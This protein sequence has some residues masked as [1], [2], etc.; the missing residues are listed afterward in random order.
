MDWYI[1]S[2]ICGNQRCRLL[3]CG[4]FFSLALKC[5]FP[6]SLLVILLFFFH[7]FLFKS[8]NPLFFFVFL[9]SFGYYTASHQIPNGKQT[10]IAKQNK[11]WSE[12]HFRF[13]IKNPKIETK[14][15]CRRKG[16]RI[17]N[18]THTGMEKETH[19]H[20]MWMTHKNA[21]MPGKLPENG[22][23]QDRRTKTI[24]RIYIEKE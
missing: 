11:V 21:K 22:T 6:F 16:Y 9:F 23:G 18:Q 7:S 8:A 17:W 5:P 12:I 4:L 10:S 15:E 13:D 2:T 20:K 3:A 1:L 14:K 24:Y 19:T